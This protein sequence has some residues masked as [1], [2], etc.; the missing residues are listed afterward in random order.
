[1]RSTLCS[2]QT[3]VSFTL[4]SVENPM[5]NIL[6]ILPKALLVAATI[7]SCTACPSHVDAPAVPAAPVCTKPPIV[8]GSAPLKCETDLNNDVTCCLYAA[9]ECL[10][11]A[12]R[13]G[14]Q[15]DDWIPIQSQCPKPRNCKDGSI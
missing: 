3:S 15:S 13:T 6:S 10:L 5:K 14:C 8:N 1:M 9:G 7:T 4:T 2:G 12:C 11:V